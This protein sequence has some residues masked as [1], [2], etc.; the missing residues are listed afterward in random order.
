MVWHKGSWNGKP[1]RKA[2]LI[3]EDTAMDSHDWSLSREKRTSGPK[4]NYMN[5]VIMESTAGVLQRGT[6][7]SVP[8]SSKGQK[9]P[10]S[11]SFLE[12]KKDFIPGQPSL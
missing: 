11:Y 12:R 5:R 9:I 3:G 2:E 6:D 8:F 1:S 7:P 10:C 4:Q